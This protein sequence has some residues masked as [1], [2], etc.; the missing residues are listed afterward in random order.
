MVTLAR[1]QEHEIRRVRQV[2][3]LEV[4]ESLK[5]IAS[6]ATSCRGSATSVNGYTYTALSRLE[7]TD[8]SVAY[9]RSMIM[10]DAAIFTGEQSDQREHD[11]RGSGIYLTVT[12]PTTWKW[13]GRTLFNLEILHGSREG[14][15]GLGARRPRLGVARLRLKTI[16]TWSSVVVSRL[17]ARTRAQP[18]QLG[19]VNSS[20]CKLSEKSILSSLH[21]DGDSGH[22][23][24]LITATRQPVRLRTQYSATT[25]TCRY[26]S[27]I[28][29]NISFAQPTWVKESQE[30]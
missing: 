21:G 23:P 3:T 29:T 25:T 18:S 26:Q 2:V 30:D 4:L 28:F 27:N 7:S 6:G 16:E 20:V 12:C 9:G 24:A 19:P 1:L 11:G 5:G 8:S 17:L 13:L 22:R 10:L 14:R 15:R